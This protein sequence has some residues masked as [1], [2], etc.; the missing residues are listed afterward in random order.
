MEFI[1]LYRFSPIQNKEELLEAIKFV[2]LACNYLCKQSFGEYLPNAGNIGIF[3]HYDDEY[4]QLI[5]LRK[6]MTE[7]SDNVN[8]KYFRLNEPI[9]IP[10]QNDIPET[11]YTHLM[12]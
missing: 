11:T 3:C 8:Q 10:A 9:V 4:D 7:A 1:K 6:E 2:H 5:R 12:P